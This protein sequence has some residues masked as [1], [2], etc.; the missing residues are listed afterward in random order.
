MIPPSKRSLSSE[1]QY[2]GKEFFLSNNRC[3]EILLGESS[4]VSYETSET[5]STPIVS[6]NSVSVLRRSARVT[7]PL[8]RYGFIGLISQLDNDLKTYGEAI[9]DIDSDKWL[10]AMKSKMDMMGSNQVWTL[11]DPPNGINPVGCKWVYKHK[12]GA[13]V[14]VTTFKARLIAKDYTQQPKMDMKTTFL[15]DFVEKET[16]MDQSEGFTSVEEEQKAITTDSTIESEYIA[17]SEAATEAVWMKNYIQEFDVVPS[18]PEPIV[19]SAI[20]TGR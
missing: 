3:N 18:I 4:E 13:N 10:E 9:M 17:A 2:F 20:T 5:T 15:N 8:E 11:M 19:S 12:L 16:Y 1:M 7:Q 14:E 6:T